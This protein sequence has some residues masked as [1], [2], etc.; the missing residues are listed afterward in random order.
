MSDFESDTYHYSKFQ[1]NGIA[2]AGDFVELIIHGID[3][4]CVLPG[5]IISDVLLKHRPIITKKLKA[6]IFLMENLGGPIIEGSQML[7]HIHNLEVVAVIRRIISVIEKNDKTTI[8]RP[9]FIL[10][11]ANACIEIDLEKPICVEPFVQCRALG[12]IVLRN[13]GYTIA[14][15]I[16]V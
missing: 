4:T 3:L 2:I 13:E 16:L 5:S 1:K 8:A 6:T 10:G 11:G 9:R 15:G 14:V 7:L 12:R